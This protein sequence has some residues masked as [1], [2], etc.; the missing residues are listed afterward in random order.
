M[1]K[2]LV[3]P[4]ANN[5]Q[6]LPRP[7]RSAVWGYFFYFKIQKFEQITSLGIVLRQAQDKSKTWI[8]CSPIQCRHFSVGIPHPLQ[9]SGPNF[10]KASQFA[11]P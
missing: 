3:N 10:T 7:Q 2:E 6:C 5:S 8:G 9:A 11:E 1:G 4:R